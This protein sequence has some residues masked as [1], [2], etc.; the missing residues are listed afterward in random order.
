MNNNPKS[1]WRVF[2]NLWL[3]DFA[4]PGRKKRYSNALADELPMDKPRQRIELLNDA[5]ELGCELMEVWEED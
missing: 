4:Q 2:G 1:Y 3:G 5:A